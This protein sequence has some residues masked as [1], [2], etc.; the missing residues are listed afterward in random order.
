[1]A[2]FQALLTDA[3]NVFNEDNPFYFVDAWGDYYWDDPDRLV[4]QDEDSPYRNTSGRVYLIVKAEWEVRMRVRTENWGAFKADDFT[5]ETKAAYDM[6][7]DTP[8]LATGRWKSSMTFTMRGGSMLAVAVDGDEGRWHRQGS[9]FDW[10]SRRRSAPPPNV[11]YT[12][13][14][15]P[16]YGAHGMLL[17]LSAPYG[18]YS[19]TAVK[20]WVFNPFNDD[21]RIDLISYNKAPAGTDGEPQSIVPTVGDV[22]SD[23]VPSYEDP[24]GWGIS[25]LVD[26]GTDANGDRWEVR[27]REQNTEDRWYIIVDGVINDELSF[28]DD[29]TGYEQAVA[30]ARLIAE[31]RRERAKV[32]DDDENKSLAPTLAFAG[33]GVVALLVLIILARRG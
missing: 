3:G 27:V 20:N 30:Q 11:L 29:D 21:T 13:L 5:A 17:S 1:M 26:S 24:Q 6:T 32:K 10:E 19:S 28:P 4:L 16:V 8:F 33:F 2:T 15:G 14:R 25:V 18:D 12:G 9:D 22:V 7:F 23:Q 31:A